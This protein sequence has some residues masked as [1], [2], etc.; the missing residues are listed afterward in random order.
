MDLRKQKKEDMLSKRRNVCVEDDEPVSPLQD[1]SN[2]HP[3]PS[4]EEIKAGIF[5]Q[6]FQEAFRATQAARKILSRERNPPIDIL[7]EAGIVP[8]LVHFLA[9]STPNLHETNLMQFEAA[10]ALTNIAS[11][12]GQQTRVVVEAGAVPHFIRLL[13]SPDMNVCEQAVWALGN[14]AGDGSELRDLVTNL[15]AVKPLLSLIA[16][17]TSETFLRNVVWTISNLCRNKNPSPKVEVMHQIL[18]TLIKLL[19]SDDSELLADACWAL[20]Y[21]S[22]GANDRIQIVV[23]SGAIPHLVKLV[24]TINY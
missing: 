17:G 4:V 7:I 9:I 11:G 12:S 19:S 5:S 15:G 16:P 10:W 21:L 20:S 14:I 3:L 22:D 13:S 1:Q 2:R 24:R 8:K 18:P 6:D 23:D